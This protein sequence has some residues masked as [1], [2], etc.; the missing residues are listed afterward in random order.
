MDWRGTRLSL[1]GDVY[2]RPIIIGFNMHHRDSV[3]SLK[4]WIPTAM[5]GDR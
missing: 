4:S 5:N 1:P 2:A 3:L